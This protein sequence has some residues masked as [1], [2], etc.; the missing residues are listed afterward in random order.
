[1][2]T[3]VAEGISKR[4]RIGE[5]K[6]GYQTLRDTLSHAAR[7]AFRL[8]HVDHSLE[9]LWALKDVS[10][11]VDEGEVVGFIGRNGSGKSTL[12]KILTRITPPT[13][14]V[15]SIRGRVGSILEVGTG[16][17]P[18]LTGRENTY[19]NGAILGMKRREISAKFD[20]IV[21]FSGIGKLIDT[22]VKRYSSGMY[23]RLAFAVA[24]HLDPEVLIIDEVLAVGDYEFQQRCMGRIED[25]S[26]SGRTVIF[27]SHDMQA[28]TRLC[29]R[30]YWLDSGRVMR[31]GPS[32]EVVSAY[33]QGASGSGAATTFGAEEAPGTAVLRLL[34]ARVVDMN[35]DIASTVD[36]REPIGIEVRFVVLGETGP[37]FPKLKLAN[38]RGEVVF[39]ALDP[40]PRWR[41]APEPG[42]YTCT[43]WIPANLLN[44]GV[45]GVDVAVASMSGPGL[46]NHVNVPS[47]VK[48]HVHDPGLGD[49]A[50]G[51]YTGQLRGGVL[52]LLDWTTEFVEAR[53]Y[54]TA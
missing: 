10:F 48:F 6:A 37:L 16:F 18:E 20:E 29:S 30:A 19:L 31:E 8:E 50:K 35:G 9:E 43:A 54:E 52:P 40:D 32:G 38:D 24:A 15:A 44:E 42:T 47:V 28:I 25:I 21:E 2:T 4:Y 14:G 45:I 12:L 51:H 27:V 46:V 26:T 17:H 49:T 1:M 33:L 39:N 13:E 22:P 11:S 34:A 23:V 53:A 5:Y 41:S 36:V 7:R 3:I